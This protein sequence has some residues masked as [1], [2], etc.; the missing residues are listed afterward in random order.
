VDR[1]CDIRTRGVTK[2]YWSGVEEQVCCW[3]LALT[4]NVLYINTCCIARY[5]CRELVCVCVCVC[6]LGV[7]I[8]GRGF[9][10]IKSGCCCCRQDQIKLL[11]NIDNMKQSS[12][13]GKSLRQGCIS[14]PIGN[15]LVDARQLPWAWGIDVEDVLGPRLLNGICVFQQC[16]SYGFRSKRGGRVLS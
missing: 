4:V 9:Q 5:T 2:S 15:G 6:L 13:L 1:T 8:I 12:E 10:Q 14:P 11:H 7:V 16:G 3:R